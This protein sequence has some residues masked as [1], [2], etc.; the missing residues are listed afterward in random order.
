VFTLLQVQKPSLGRFKLKEGRNLLVELCI[1]QLVKLVNN[2]LA[3]I[4]YKGQLSIR[5]VQRSS[6]SAAKST[7]YSS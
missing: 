1:T 3:L 6:K 2:R 7:I 4:S 5:R